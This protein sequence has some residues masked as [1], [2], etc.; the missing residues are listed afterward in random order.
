MGG[1]GSAIKN[2]ISGPDTPTPPP[3]PP[4]TPSEDPAVKAKQDALAE[5]E[6]KRMGRAAT[7]L[8]GEQSTAETAKKT[9]L[10]S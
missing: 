9:L 6:R 5:E 10:G 1:I 4:P 8:F 2:I 7:V 3:A